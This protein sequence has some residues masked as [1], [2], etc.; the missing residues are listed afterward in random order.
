M[1]PLIESHHDRIIELC[2]QHGIKRLCLVGSLARGDDRPD[3]DA[4]FLY[5]FH[6]GRTP[7]FEFVQVED[8]FA[9]ALG[10]P[11]DL[12]PERFLRPWLREYFNDHLQVV[13]DDAA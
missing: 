13:Y 12:I 2:K 6:P 7:G 9:E 3:S 1:H 8:A 11:V 5:Q 4:D 10:R